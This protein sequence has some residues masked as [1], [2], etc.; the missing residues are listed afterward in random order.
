[1]RIAIGEGEIRAGHAREVGS[2]GRSVKENF[3]GAFAA[4]SAIEWRIDRALTFAAASCFRARAKIF[5]EMRAACALF[6][7]LF[8]NVSALSR[9]HTTSRPSAARSDRR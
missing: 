2:R 8:D 6:V 1:M 5:M 7:L 9:H 3:D 4:A